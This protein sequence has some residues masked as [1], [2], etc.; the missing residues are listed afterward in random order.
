MVLSA[1][2]S[3][4][5]KEPPVAGESSAVDKTNG[6]TTLLAVVCLAAVGAF[7]ALS[8]PTFDPPALALATGVL[9]LNVAIAPLGPFGFFSAAPACA[10]GLA[11]SQ[12]ASLAGLTVLLSITL[13]TVLYGRASTAARLKEGLLDLF[14]TLL[15]IAAAFAAHALPVALVVAA[16]T[17][18]Y[19]GS[20]A[21]LA[22]GFLASLPRVDRMEA[23]PAGRSLRFAHL[24]LP[25][26]GAVLA[27]LTP[28]QALPLIALLWVLQSLA[29]NVIHRARAQVVENTRGTLVRSFE[30][31][32]S[33]RDTVESTRRELAEVQVERGTIE[34]FA[35]HLAGSQT[36][37]ATLDLILDEASRI[38]GGQ[39]LAI[40]LEDDAKL[41]PAR[42]RLADVVNFELDVVAG[43]SEPTV[44]RAWRQ[45]TALR[46]TKGGQERRLFRTVEHAL[47]APLQDQGMLYVGRTEPIPYTHD[48]LDRLLVVASYGGLALQSTRRL[49]QRAQALRLQGEA[50][51]CLEVS[52]AEL[53]QTHER[54]RA[55]QEQLV[56]TSKLAA[57]GQLAAGVAHEINTPLGA[58]QLSVE[59]AAT[60]FSSDPEKAA[61]RL[62]T[63]VSAVKR[64]RAIIDKLLQYAS[65]DVRRD[66]QSDLSRVVGEAL[67][68]VRP[69]F[70]QEAVTVTFDLQ[71]GAVV[72]GNSNELQQVAVNLLLNAL[73]ASRR[74]KRPVRA[75]TC[76]H[77]DQAGFGV[78]DRGEGIRPES[79]PRIFEPFYTE[80]PIGQ[81]TG[82]GL[83]V[84][85]QI[86]ERHGGRFD[87]HSHLEEGSTFT[88][89]LPLRTSV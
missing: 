71:E 20:R 56:Q 51:Q 73:D 52:L 39:S 16:V 44:E 19:A 37:E 77:G 89:W 1:A 3:T 10:I 24:V 22:R 72:T 27:T 83:S 74:D 7:V 26:A 38:V 67:E 84:S 28:A 49:E 81:G 50:N 58:I 25:V 68:L 86:V 33:A 64:A 63:A 70:D 65:T 42:Y 41:A 80:K 47:A 9:V 53:A 62:D 76:V 82:L 43:V 23:L 54:L 60:S 17:L 11:L 88:V 57:V 36:L 12:N 21:V 15:A 31:Y 30:I 40:F 5:P 8:P 78:E 35:R 46:V 18:V 6:T 4:P 32:E 14:P 87:V 79:L 66:E 29:V 48:D 45:R 59:M 13:R 34:A 75:F 61:R 55:S 2:G 69:R 85:H